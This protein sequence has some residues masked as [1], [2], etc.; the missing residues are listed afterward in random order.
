MSKT[1][2][3][4]CTGVAGLMTT[5]GSHPCDAIN[6]SV[7]FRCTQAS[8]CTEIQLAPA[9]ANAP[10][11]SS[12]FSIIK[13]QSKGALAMVF[14]SEATTGGPIVRFGTK[15]PSI[16][17][18][19]STVPPPSIAADASAPSCAKLAER[20]D[21]A[22][23]IKTRSSN[24]SLRFRIAAIARRNG[25]AMRTSFRVAQK[26]ANALVQLGRNDVLEFASLVARFGIFDRKRIF[27]QPLRK[28]MTA[29]H[30]ARPLA[31][32]RRQVHFAVAQRDQMQIGHAAQNARGWLIGQ[33]RKM[34]GRSGGAQPL[35]LRGLAFFPADPDLLEQMIEADFV[36][37]GNGRATIGGV[38]QRASQRMARAVLQ[39]I[40]MQA[41]V[42]QLDPPV[43][44]AG[45]V[46]VVRN[47]QDSVAAAVQL[48]ENFQHNGLVGFVEITGR[49]IGQN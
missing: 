42:R 12:G 15:C 1:S 11:K 7:R 40:E 43:R 5:A 25:I 48:A 35:D 2:S 29:H 28:A 20:M 31:A 4:I 26:A 45:D 14:R 49:L 16:T 13:W 33:H 39:R 24:S 21:G 36:V 22:S 17:S 19:C 37:T 8:W 27:E 6:C 38:G 18:R 47:H 9:S 46:R 10:I 3:S 23:S 41:A 32:R 30:V 34:P 44:L